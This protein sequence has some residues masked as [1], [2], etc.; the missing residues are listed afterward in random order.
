MGTFDD[1][2]GMGEGERLP[3]GL[4][5]PCHASSFLF[6]G[7]SEFLMMEFHFFVAT[8]GTFSRSLSCIYMYARQKLRAHRT[9]IA[10]LGQPSIPLGRKGPNF[11]MTIALNT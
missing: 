1:Y 10:G 11:A 5:Y 2:L 3:V 9:E 6:S 4:S 8:S 7:G